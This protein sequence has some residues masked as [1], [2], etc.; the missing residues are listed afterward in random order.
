MTVRAYLWMSASALALGLSTT[1]FSTPAQAAC[2]LVGSTVTCDGLDDDGFT[3]GNGLTLNTLT[4][5][6]VQSVYDGNPSTF[7]PAFRAAVRLGTNARVSNNG[8]ILGRG[9]CGLGIDT[10]NG[11]TLTNDGDIRTDS[12]VAYAIL[13]GSNFNITNRGTIHTVNAGSVAIVGVNNGLITNAASGV[14]ET[15]AA[16]APAI[17]VEDSNTITNA[18]TIRTSGSGGIGIDAGATN[19]I[20]NTGTITATG[21]A[22]SGI[23]LRGAGNTIINSGTIS[24]I[25]TQTPR[26]GENSIGIQLDGNNNVI[27]NTGTISGDYAGVQI[28][29]NNNIISNGR[30]ITAN[31]PTSATTLGAAVLINGNNNILNNFSAIRGNGSAAVRVTGANTTIYNGGQIT[32]DVILGSGTNTLTMGN[33]TFISGVI[34][35]RA[36]TSNKLVFE[37][38][39]AV[40]SN[41]ILGRFD[42]EK[43]GTGSWLLGGDVSLLGNVRISGGN[44]V[45]TNSRLRAGSVTID[46]QGGFGGTGVISGAG[47][48]SS[49]LP[50]S[51]T[52]A[53]ELTPA[54]GAIGDLTIIGS[55]TQ[56]RT[57]RIIFDIT[58]SAS[59]RISVGGNV[60]LDGEL[61]LRTTA[62]RLNSGQSFT[63]INVPVGAGTILGSFASVTQLS[64]YFITGAINV[65]SN[66]VTVN[67]QRNAFVS[68]AR[69]PEEAGLAA[70]F[71][72]AVVSGSDPLNLV[73]RLDGMTAAQAQ[74]TFASLTSDS[75]VAA[76]TWTVL[77]AQT[78]TDALAPWLDLSSTTHTRG[79]W[80][81]WGSVLAR[82][83]ETGA[84]I[85]SDHF[86]YQMKG[87][88]AGVDYAI[89]DDTRIGMTASYI[90][91][92]T[93]FASGN[94]KNELSSTALGLYA[95]H[96]NE[97]WFA[98][99]GGFIGD[100]K[101][102][103]T[104]LN[105]YVDPLAL[106]IGNLSAKADTDMHSVFGEAGY[107]VLA[108]DWQI[109]PTVGINYAHAKIGALSETAATGLAVQA[110]KAS[111]VRGE[112]GLRANSAEGP[113]RLSVGAFWSQDLKDNDRTASARLVGFTGSDFVI[114]G[115]AEK[116]GWLKT[117]AAASMD[118]TPALTAKLAWTGIL[119]DRLGG[120][121]ATA[122]LSYRW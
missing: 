5:S 31:A 47:V 122:G 49:F 73:P 110:Q 65:T 29:G 92:D 43:T 28:S 8:Q 95:T 87:V 116:R 69:T 93:Y 45:L 80:R 98:N 88:S 60:R 84:K 114:V 85:S 10:S 26:D 36:G 115:R 15:T 58:N 108:S 79:T 32:G 50:T 25:S 19:S 111:S 17:Y 53:G 14:I 46:A 54:T 91:G 3:G 71:D 112:I 76:Q 21:I 109:K 12:S 35:G 24:A 1:M 89:T 74:S 103:A 56:T 90:D 104:R 77:A 61:V 30:T 55:L 99:V 96:Q 37:G 20:T 59:D 40:F 83:G 34:D 6:F 106:V 48:G 118:L 9:N 52:N 113:V 51:V 94:A 67:I 117:Q 75:P 62:S 97:A 22:S 105:G 39:G 18:G 72:R 64:P 121:A 11:L 101:V 66:T 44:F 23:H 33:I 100:G 119:N 13:T 78:T 2:T 102:S 41:L 107:I 4:G 38:A 63:L 42:A 86:D 7:C 27:S 82:T 57:G 70:A 16:D 68:V 81:T 120:H